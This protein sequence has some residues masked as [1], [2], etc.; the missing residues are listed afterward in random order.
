M[1][2]LQLT[3]ISSG[4]SFIQKKLS[5]NKERIIQKIFPNFFIQISANLYQ[6]N[7]ATLGGNIFR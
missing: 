1:V 2:K 4:V 3:V 6:R 7:D 5:T